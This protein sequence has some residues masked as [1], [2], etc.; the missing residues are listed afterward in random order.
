MKKK[1]LIEDIHCS[2]C[3]QK[4]EDR[5]SNFQDIKIFINP[6][7]NM[8]QLEYNE[9]K[10]TEADIKKILQ[11]TKYTFVE[12]KISEKLTNDKKD[13]NEKFKILFLSILTILIVIISMGDMLFHYVNDKNYNYFVFTQ[14]ILLLPILIMTKDIFIKGIKDINMQ[15]LICLG[16]VSSIIYSIYLVY[17]KT[18][19]LY[20]EAASVILTLHV[21]GDKLENREKKKTNESY[22]NLLKLKPNVVN[23]K[24]YNE[25]IIKDINEVEIDDVIEIKTGDIVPLDGKILEGYLYL[26]QSIITGESKLIEKK[27]AEEIISGAKVIKGYAL[28][29]VKSKNENSLFTNLINSIENA[30]NKKPKITRVADSL[31]RYFIPILLIFTVLIGIY[32]FV[33]GENITNI[34]TYCISILVISCP[35]SIGL[36]IPTV[37]TKAIGEGVK[38]GIVVSNPEVLETFKDSK[39][40]LLDKTGTITKGK[41]IVTYFNIKD[42]DIVSKIYNIEKKSEHILSTAIIK[43]IE[44]NFYDV[45]IQETNFKLDVGYGIKNDEIIIGNKEYMLKNN[46]P[47]TYLDE[48]EKLQEKG[49]TVVFVSDFIK[50][51]GII[52]ISDEIKEDSKKAISELKKLGYKPIMITGD[53]Y[54]VSKNIADMVGIEE[55][56]SNMTP[57]KK[58]EV[59]T[60]I[61]QEGHKTIMVGDGVN[62][63]LSLKHSNISVS[64]KMAVD[65]A[66]ENS[67][68]ILMN[69]SLYDLIKVYKLSKITMIYIYQNLA[70][71][72]LYN[73]IGIALASGL[74]G[75]TLSPMIAAFSMV[76]SSLSVMLN[77]IRLKLK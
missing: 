75:V 57:N 69:N 6:I 66:I 68:I 53:D 8:A 7:N 70:W 50:I 33:K 2:S 35:C 71:A 15:T 45:K 16:V 31:S 51:L 49:E 62:D 60:N 41:P 17:T 19:H 64:L 28:L 1:Y 38:N 52:A 13:N 27:E 34:F 76:F 46:I 40:I 77:A 73:I 72:F 32:W 25:F 10:Y 39:Y 22:I 48:Y 43:Y 11:S 3:V 44:N 21:I 29:K 54:K 12:E 63:T 14:I 56:Y 26:D 4:I 9:N 47:L 67:D 55:F 59:L 18:S 61:Q 36:A 42:K 58:M 5:I 65:I 24:K 37:I 23:V 20:F 30:N 74:L